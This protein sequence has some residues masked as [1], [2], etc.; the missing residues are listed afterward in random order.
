MLVKPKDKDHIDRKI[1][2]IFW[3]QCGELA[4]DEEYKGKHPGPFEKYIRST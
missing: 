1:G 4:C 2:A 3:Y